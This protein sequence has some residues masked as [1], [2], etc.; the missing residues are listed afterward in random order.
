MDIQPVQIYPAVADE[1]RL[2]LKDESIF[3]Q[4]NTFFIR[5]GFQQQREV[6]V[7]G[8]MPVEETLE[9]L[10][11]HWYFNEYM[12]IIQCPQDGSPP[13]SRHGRRHRSAPG[14][15]RVQ[16]AVNSRN[17]SGC[18]STADQGTMMQVSS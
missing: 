16:S 7:H 1:T 14:S 17:G 15:L 5:Q 12:Y 18:R 4:G 2:F 10:L 3:L 9:G 11:Q 13:L 8:G 6:V